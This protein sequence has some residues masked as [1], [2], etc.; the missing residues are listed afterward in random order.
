[1]LVGQRVEI[2]CEGGELPKP[3]VAEATIGWRHGDE[4]GIV[5]TTLAA[6]SAP[7]VADY[8]SRRGGR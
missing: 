2:R 1:M 8:V 6:E 3:I 5:F 4:A 7:A